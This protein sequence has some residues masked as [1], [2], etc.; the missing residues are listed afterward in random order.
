MV[1]LEAMAAGLPVIG[2]NAGGI[3]DLVVHETTGLLVDPASREEMRA[4]VKRILT[5]QSEAAK[6]SECSR[7]VAREKFHPL[8][9]A[10][11]HLE[12]YREV[13]GR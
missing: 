1:V 9:I 5:H 8:V 4:A 6:M 12:I 10:K 13:T 3:P 2:A 7:A 11:R